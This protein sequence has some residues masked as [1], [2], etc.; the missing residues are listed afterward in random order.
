MKKPLIIMIA[1]LL[2]I[3][4]TGGGTA[5]YFIK[6]EKANDPNNIDLILERSLET[7]EITTSLKDGA[8][9]KVSF[10]IQADSLKT[11]EELE[12]RM[13]QVDNIVINYLSDKT[14]PEIQNNNID[15]LQ[16]NI[17]EQVN[18]VMEH[19]EV[20]KIYITSYVLQ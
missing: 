9:V 7:K 8:F 2:V 4:L 13:Y 16:K 10:K 19:G 3:G 11:K 6:K 15:S 12:K 17:K 14:A 5:F 20:E 1:L 18:D